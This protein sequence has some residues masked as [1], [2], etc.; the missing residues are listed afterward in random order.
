MVC[1]QYRQC[2]TAIQLSS[3]SNLNKKDGVWSQNA[4]SNGKKHVQ[5]SEIKMVAEDEQKETLQFILNELTYSKLEDCATE[6]NAQ[7]AKVKK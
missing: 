2:F 1:N 3:L 4:H 5:L 6:L 7:R